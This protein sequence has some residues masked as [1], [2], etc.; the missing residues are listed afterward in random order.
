MKKRYAPVFVLTALVGT[1]LHFA[2]DLCPVP[3][4]GLLA[5]V[6]ESVWEHL[7]LLFWPFLAAGFVLTC[8]QTDKPA[9]WSGVLLAELL[10]PLALLGV[11]YP[12]SAGFGVQS[13]VLDVLLYYLVLASGFALARRVSGTG[14]LAFLS[15]VLVILTGLY[16]AALILFTLAPP[17]LP[18]FLANP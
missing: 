8:G 11:Y 4:V 3:L 13:V 1:A 10:M 2:Y 14:R 6:N 7:K 16:G 17:G 9:A 18:I 15:G 12:L 5:P